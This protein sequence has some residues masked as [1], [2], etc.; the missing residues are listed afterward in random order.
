MAEK[1]VKTV[2]VG[3]KP[4]PMKFFAV[5]EVE[6][7]APSCI[8]RLCTLTLSRLIIHKPL[9]NDLNSVIIA[10]KMQNSKRILRSNEIII[11]PGG[12][13]DTELDLT[14]SLQYPHYLKRDC[15]LQVMLQR[16]KKYKNKTILGYKT[17]ALGQVNMT[18][19]L[20][21]THDKDLSLYSEQKDNTEKL[22]T[23]VM[24]QLSSQPVDHTENGQRKTT[25]SDVDRS[26]DIDNESYDEDDQEEWSNDDISDPEALDEDGRLRAR[27][28]NRAQGRGV[29]S[30]RGRVNQQR[31]FKQKIVSLL[32]K[33]K[34]TEES[35]DPEE[36]PDT[37]QDPN[38]E[39]EDLIDE[40]AESM[41]DSGQEMDQDTVSVI[42]TPKPRLRPFFQG[43]MSAVEFDDSSKD[44]DKHSDDAPSLKKDPDSLDKEQADDQKSSPETKGKIS[45]GRSRSYREGKHSKGDRQRCHS[46]GPI[47]GSPHK[48]LMEH[49]GV[50]LGGS[51]EN[52]PETIMLVNTSE[53]QGQL[54]QQKFQDNS[55]NMICTCGEP[56]VK[57][58][59][60]ALVSKIQKYCNSNSK[61]PS[62]IRVCIAGS[63]SYV[64]TILR[65]YVEQFSAKPPDWQT[66]INFL[67]IPF[68]SSSIGRYIGSLDNTYTLLFLDQQWKD[69]FEKNE[70]PKLDSQD[71]MS[72]VSKYVNASGSVAQ[73]PIAEAMVMCRSKSGEEDSSQI[74]IPF[75]SEV[76]I[77]SYDVMNASMDFDDTGNTMFNSPS[78]SS[79]PPNN[80]ASLEKPKIDFSTPPSSP[81]VN[82]APNSNLPVAVTP[83][84][85]FVELQVDYWTTVTKS[86]SADKMDKASKKD[87]NK[88]T[89]KTTFRSLQVQRLA[90]N[91][92]DLN[93]FS[94]VVVTK[95]KKH[96]KFVRPIN[97]QRSPFLDTHCPI[98]PRPGVL[99]S[100]VEVLTIHVMRLGKKAKES[101]SK[102][103]IV[104]GIN[105]L[106]C[107]TKTQS[108]SLKV[109]VDGVEW[110]G[111][112]FFQLSTQW[113]THIKHFPISIHINP[114][115][116]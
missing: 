42:S 27:K 59:I 51:E 60:S 103:Q 36:F 52:L 14:F 112:K 116:V 87:G 90:Q 41:S 114:D 43:R 7:T 1:S 2:G 53:W 113:Q 11:P 46:T 93:A 94:M 57:A 65:P 13:L 30:A 70:A 63:D 76:K 32:R 58:A 55:Y 115:P 67:I 66:Y 25:L 15:K 31:N 29:A 84:G 10:V 62:A 37:N 83:S 82:V 28:S 24:L 106:I 21:R 5:L 69:T 100:N 19:V 92:V 107:T 64:N 97:Q 34:I 26:P 18:H 111:V 8:P 108:Y 78:L 40:L 38:D 17:L 101:E 99:L 16:R 54:F 89:L 102:S 77:G 39:I 4:V 61:A 86:D 79:S 47:H 75:I 96:I 85:E 50:V 95:E 44:P 110:T 6:K 35:L 88:C 73:I 91:P 80:L 9:E 49:L 81:N 45:H 74:L 20:Q 109:M 22:S 71:I 48:A 98:L 72:R 56:D 68:G 3:T 104:E 12:L 33:F 23:L 105:R